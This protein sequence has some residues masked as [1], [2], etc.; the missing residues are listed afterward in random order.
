MSNLKF[1]FRW[2][3]R[4][5]HK[6]LGLGDFAGSVLGNLLTVVAHL[7][8]AFSSTANDLLWQIPIYGLAGALLLRILSAP[9][10]LWN[11]EHHRAISAEKANLELLQNATAADRS[12]FREPLKTFYAEGVTVRARLQATDA[13]Y[14]SGQAELIWNWSHKVAMWVCENMGEYALSAFSTITSVDRAISV[15]VEARGH[16]ALMTKLLENLKDL[17]R[18]GEWDP[19]GDPVHPLSGCARFVG[20]PSDLPFTGAP[21]PR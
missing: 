2:A 3:K 18:S 17:I 21:T 5:L 15:S 14:L 4:A 10:E 11:E 13:Q 16:V 1:C 20:S 19:D 12:K 7:V 8:P 6:S 9:K